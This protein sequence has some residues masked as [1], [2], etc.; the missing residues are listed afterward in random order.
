VLG[1]DAVQI[2]EAVFTVADKRWS[3]TLTF[4]ARGDVAAI[5]LTRAG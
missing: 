5:A 1:A 3:I 4:L 2:A